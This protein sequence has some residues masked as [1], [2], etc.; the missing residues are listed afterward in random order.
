MDLKSLAGEEERR[1][2]RSKVRDFWVGNKR[3]QDPSQ[4]QGLFP[5]PKSLTT[6]GLPRAAM[7]NVS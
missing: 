7:E 6:P 4:S 3:G 1:K 2:R 5:K